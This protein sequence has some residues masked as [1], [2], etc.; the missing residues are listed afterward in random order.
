MYVRTYPFLLLRL[1]PCNLPRL[2]SSLASLRGTT[3]A[4]SSLLHHSSSL[5][6]KSSVH[7]TLFKLSHVETVLIFMHYCNNGNSNSNLAHLVVNPRSRKEDGKIQCS[8]HACIVR[9]QLIRSSSMPNPIRSFHRASMQEGFNLVC[10]S[11]CLNV[12]GGDGWE[13]MDVLIL[14]LMCAVPRDD[15]DVEVEY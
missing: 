7:A 4:W 9:E 14:S 8:M 13:L 10:C 3:S 12:Q 1:V 5:Q 2:G 11:L 15:Q 6:C